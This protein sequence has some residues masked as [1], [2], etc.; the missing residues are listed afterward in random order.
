MTVL[1]EVHPVFV[2]HDTGPGHPE[3]P[4]RLDAVVA[5]I[6]SAGLSDAVQQ[7][8]P[9]PATFDDMASVHPR[10]YLDALERFCA[11]GG[12]Y[13]DGDTHVGRSSFDA[14]RVAAGAG[15]DAAARLQRGEA[16]AAFC[17]VRPPG[18]HAR[19]AQSM[20]FCLVN[21]VAVAAAAL[22]NR[23]ERVAVIDWDAHH[24]NGTQDAFYE[25]PRV[26]YVSLH[27]WPLYPGT[28]GPD[29]QGETL[30]N[31]P[32]PAGSTDQEYL[33]AFEARVAPAVQRFDPEL[34]LV[35]AG[36]DAH[37]EDPI[38]QMLVTAA[39]FR[40]LARRS[41]ALA[42]RLAAVLEGGYNLRT[43]PGLVEAALAGFGT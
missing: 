43:L 29:D 40:E 20:G 23:G 15:L 10:E 42:P 11:E 6:E 36:F 4:A 27:Q 16:T 25:D 32:L 38:A 7:V 33:D 13:L 41:A 39:G 30:V 14:A 28:G 2:K 24:G 1:L 26:L 22:A 8:A 12:G 34:L 9:E 31:V 37:E 19:P 18:H 5:G 21:N 3:R 17:V 35:S